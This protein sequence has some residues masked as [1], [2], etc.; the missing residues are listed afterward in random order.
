MKNYK[1]PVEFFNP[2]RNVTVATAAPVEEG[3]AFGAFA[4]GTGRSGL[5][6]NERL[7]DVAQ[8]ATGGRRAKAGT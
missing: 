5:A 1:L 8:L 6:I 7:S 3:G 4:R 2:L